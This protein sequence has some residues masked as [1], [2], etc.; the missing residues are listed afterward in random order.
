MRKGLGAG[1]P[2]ETAESNSVPEA[3]Q[4]SRLLLE[5]AIDWP[6]CGHWTPYWPLP[7]FICRHC[8]HAKLDL[9]IVKK[10]AAYFV[11]ESR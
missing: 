11:R 8:G 1:W 2:I 5:L 6:R 3:M 4:P 10:A 7:A 9:E